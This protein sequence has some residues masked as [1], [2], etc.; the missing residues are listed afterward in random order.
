[1]HAAAVWGC[2]VG[3]HKQ[4]AVLSNCSNN[5]AVVA[6]KQTDSQPCAVMNSAQTMEKMHST[7]VSK[8]LTT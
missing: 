4:A 7:T 8:A 5:L 1:M 3:Q 2:T 6:L